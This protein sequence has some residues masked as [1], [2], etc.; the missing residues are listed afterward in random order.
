MNLEEILR[1]F[2]YN[3]SQMFKKNGDLSV[4]GSKNYEKLMK[5]LSDISILTG[6]STENIIRE[7]ENICNENY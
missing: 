5:L 1:T 3:K 2:G 7:I 4:K 6:I